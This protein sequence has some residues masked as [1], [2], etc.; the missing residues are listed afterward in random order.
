MDLSSL[1][2]DVLKDVLEGPA[3]E[4]PPGVTP[5]FID[6]P[7][8]NGLA[9]ATAAVTACATAHTWVLSMIT[10][11]P[12]YFVHQWDVRVKD[13]P[14]HI[15]AIHMGVN[16]YLGAILAIK[17][18]ILLEWFRIF[19]PIGERNAFF[20]VGH[21]LLVVNTLFY[22]SAIFVENF[23]CIPLE[24]LWD[25]TVPG[26]CIDLEE[27]YIATAAFNVFSDIFILVLPQ[28]VVWK[29]QMTRRRKVGVSLIFAVG[30]LTC[31]VAIVRVYTSTSYVAAED[32]VYALSPMSLLTHIETHLLLLVIC[33]PT[34]PSVLSN[35]QLSMGIRTTL[36]SLL[37]RTGGKRTP[38][39]P[40]SSSRHRDSSA[41]RGSTDGVYRKIT[42]SDVP[43]RPLNAE[44][45]HSELLTTQPSGLPPHSLE[46]GIMRVTEFVKV[47]NQAGDNSWDDAFYRQH[48]W[49]TAPRD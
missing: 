23:T 46:T 4:P 38:S 28:K 27:Y 22:T 15:Y 47:E 13:I 19:N 33:I 16:F 26:T 10:K 42:E 34:V 25:K 6:P 20:W 29:L 35:M 3:L 32:K 5:N 45:T 8:R 41:R 21:A 40:T 48:P 2:P 49:T 30:I 9:Y 11:H 44:V 43:L 24:R 37:S 39:I 17:A 18:A 1:P 12:G 36:R 31:L 14:S 7:N